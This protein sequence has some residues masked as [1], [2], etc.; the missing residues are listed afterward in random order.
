MVKEDVTG[1]EMAYLEGEEG[2]YAEGF[3]QAL[4]LKIWTPLLEVC[5]EVVSMSQTH[6]GLGWCNEESQEE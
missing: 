3:L 4:G 1:G 2:G 5:M 6:D